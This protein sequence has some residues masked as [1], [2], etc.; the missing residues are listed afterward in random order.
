M[1]IVGD[2]EATRLVIRRTI[3]AAARRRSGNRPTGV[4]IARREEPDV[5]RA[6]R[7]RSVPRRVPIIVLSGSSGE[8]HSLQ[9]LVLGASVFMVKP[10]DVRALAREVKR[11]LRG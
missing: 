1:L 3:E 7:D 4:E 8:Q 10:A 2:D 5:I 11:L 6:L 9:S